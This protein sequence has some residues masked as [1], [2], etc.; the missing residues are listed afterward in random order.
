MI[1]LKFS[2]FCPLAEDWARVKLGTEQKQKKL[3]RF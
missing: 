3:R 1:L 2:T